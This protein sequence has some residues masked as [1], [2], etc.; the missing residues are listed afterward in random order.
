ML[1]ERAMQALE[2]LRAD[3]ETS[4]VRDGGPAFTA[5]KA[6]V[7]GVIKASV[8]D[9][10]DLLEQSYGNRYTLRVVSSYTTRAEH[11]QVRYAGIGRARGIIDAALYRLHSQVEGADE[12]VA[13]RSFDPDLWDHVRDLVEAEDWKKVSSQTAIFVEATIRK[14]AGDPTGKNGEV[15][16]GKGLMA[17][18]FVNDSELRC[19]R[20]AGE[21]EGWRGLAMGFAQALSNV[22][23]HHIN[24][25]DDA[26]RYAIGVLGLGS[27]LLTQLRH[28]H[29][30]LI[31][32]RLAGE[33]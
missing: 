18:V 26:R 21:W 15:L 33:A 32:D 25:R 23:R 20:Q 19:G 22:D 7:R 2:D 12:P 1:A 16:V 11:A 8:S 4:D 17:A 10:Q 30:T 13:G 5:W 24:E 28:E 27:L 31:E 9:A 3:A 29:A 14:W 6:K